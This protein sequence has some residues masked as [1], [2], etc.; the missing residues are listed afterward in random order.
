MKYIDA[1]FLPAHRYFEKYEVNRSNSIIYDAMNIGMF[2]AIGA[3]IW[4]YI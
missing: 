3:L 4:H 1:L 2:T